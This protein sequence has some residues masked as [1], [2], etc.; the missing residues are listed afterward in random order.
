MT[1]EDQQPLQELAREESQRIQLRGIHEPDN[2]LLYAS[3]FE[4]CQA[5]TN[6]SGSPD[7]LR[8]AHPIDM[9]A[10]LRR[11]FG[12]GCLI[13]FGNR[14]IIDNRSAAN[15]VV[16]SP[17]VITVLLEDGQFLL[18]MLYIAAKITAIPV[19]GDELER[20]F[21]S[22]TTNKNR[23]MRFLYSLWLVDCTFDLEIVALKD[24]F[25]LRPHGANDLE[26]VAQLAQALGCIGIGVAVGPILMFIPAGADAKIQPSMAQ[27]VDG[28]GHLCQ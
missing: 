3:L 10:L 24:R 19:L 1:Y 18:E 28:T 13:G 22:A 7:E 15:R 20:D 5:C 14:T 6:R 8:R 21:F 12:N 16:V 17:D 11:Q 9:L 2:Q 23:D 4:F 27:H 25:F 26:G